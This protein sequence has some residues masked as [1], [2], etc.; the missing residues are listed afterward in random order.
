VAPVG[1]VPGHAQA[2]SVP[3]QARVPVPEQAR[4]VVVAVMGVAVV[5]MGVA[6]VLGATAVPAVAAPVALEQAPV[7]AERVPVVARPGPQVVAPAEE[8][9]APP[10]P[11]AEQAQVPAPAALEPLR[12]EVRRRAREPASPTRRSFRR[13]TRSCAA[14]MPFTRGWGKIRRCGS[15]RLSMIGMATPA[16]SSSRR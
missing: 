15:G 2:G 3:E 16:A 8:Q 14:G 10:P 12:P 11:W 1:V 6:V 13:S 5:V 4:A 9:V 7:L